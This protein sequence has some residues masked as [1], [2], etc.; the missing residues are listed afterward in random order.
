MADKM[1][2]G[3]EARGERSHM[4]HLTEHIV[5]QIRLE[6]VYGSR[7]FGGRALARKYGVD[8]FTI[9]AIVNRKSWTHL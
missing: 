2:K 9:R 4:S 7:V 1:A 8:E 3:R 5:K 6:F